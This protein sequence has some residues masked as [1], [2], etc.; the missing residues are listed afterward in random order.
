[1]GL[2]KSKAER[3]QQK[4]DRDKEKIQKMASDSDR[5][6]RISKEREI[7]DA[8]RD[9][10]TER[11]FRKKVIKA[12]SGLMSME[13]KFTVKLVSAVNE[14]KRLESEHRSPDK[15]RTKIKNAYYT[16]IVVKESQERLN[17][18]ESDHE[19]SMAMRDLS[20]TLKIMNS[21]SSGSEPLKKLLFKYRYAKAEMGNNYSGDKLKGYYGKSID[22]IADK[23]KID[24]LA[25]KD[26]IDFVVSDEIYDMLMKDCSASA[27]REC[28]AKNCA[29]DIPLEEAVSIVEDEAKQASVNGEE[30]AVVGL[31]ESRSFDDIASGF[32]M[33]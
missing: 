10:L 19:W 18:I 16:L 14:A 30:P 22:E 20:D 3:E 8:H 9:T 15:A 29:A 24:E 27:I 17:R 32:N 11:D 2:F 23:E 28:V 6:D 13:Q 1:M 33:L 7:I 31:G 26:V 21:I 5:L 4:L 25:D 12:R